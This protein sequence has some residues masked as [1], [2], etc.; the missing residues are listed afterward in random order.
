MF[1]LE[2]VGLLPIPCLTLF[3]LL[4]ATVFPPPPWVNGRVNA[5]R[6]EFACSARE[7]A[8]YGGLCP[9]TRRALSGREET[10]LFP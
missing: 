9:W 3:G 5:G 10:W 2:N 6:D 8:E 1:G 7:A 4:K